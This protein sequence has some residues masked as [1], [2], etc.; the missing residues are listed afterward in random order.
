MRS[1]GGRFWG[2]VRCW[3]S[4][5]ESV[6][7][8]YVPSSFIFNNSLF[9]LSFAPFHLFLTCFSV[10]SQANLPYVAWVAAYN[11][12]FILGYLLLDLYFFP[13][14][15]LKSIYSPT[16]K[17][18]QHGPSHNSPNF[19]IPG[20]PVAS[21]Y[22]R[23][24]SPIP[25]PQTTTP[26]PRYARQDSEGRLSV[27][28]YPQPVLVGGGMRGGM[29]G[30]GGRKGGLRRMAWGQVQVGA[31]TLLEAINRNGLAVFL[32]VSPYSRATLAFFLF[33]CA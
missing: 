11:T 31:P 15:M 23:P 19:H 14:P 5:A 8:W 28:E 13:S 33:G 25:A 12:S 30:G 17:L 29:V 6:V 7:G 24:T 20:T 22:Q 18:K 3:V 27:E 26:R 32:L 10:F 4:V 21:G 9:S 16:S 2:H 1:Y